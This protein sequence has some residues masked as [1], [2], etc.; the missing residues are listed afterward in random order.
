M[1]SLG[2]HFVRSVY[3]GNG[4]LFGINLLSQRESSLFDINLLSQREPSLF[5]INLLRQRESSLFDINLLSQR[6]SKLLKS[7]NTI[8]QFLVYTY[9]L[10][11]L[12]VFVLVFIS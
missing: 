5:D 6:K 11:S 8:I 2:T 7:I 10:K 12:L 9:K 4:S 3:E 1:Q